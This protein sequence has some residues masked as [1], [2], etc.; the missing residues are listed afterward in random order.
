MT[1]DSDRFDARLDVIPTSPGVY[2]MKDTS[3]S[4][5]YVGKAKNLKNRLGS[6]FAKTPSGNGKVLAM[7]SHI[8]D[9]EYI[10]VNNELE[11]FLLESN[12]I[13]RYQPHYNILLRD[14][15]G[16]PYVCITMNEQYPRIFRSFRVGA[17]RKKGARY[18]GPFLAG[19]LFYALKTLRDVFPMKTCNRS[20][21]R[22]IGKERPCLNY[23]IGKCIAPCRGDV[24]VDDYRKVMENICLFFEGKYTGLQ[25]DME[26]KMQDA[27]MQE[28]FEIAAIFRD[29]LQSL[30]KIMES[31]KVEIA[32]LSDMDIIGMKRNTG[33][34]CI[35]KL[36]CRNGRITGSATFFFLDHKEED[37]EIISAFLSQ[38][39]SDVEE[40]PGEILLSDDILEKESMEEVLSSYA[41]HKVSLRVPK[42]GDGVRLMNMAIH[43]AASALLRRV[44]KV[45]DSKDALEAA[46]EMLQKYTGAP[47]VLGRIEA[48]DISNIGED[49]RCGA[50]VVFRNGKPEK[51]AYRLFKIKKVEGQNDYE[52]MRE[53][54]ERRFSHTEKEGAYPDLILIDGGQGHLAIAREVL[55]KMGL[56]DRIIAA[57][58]VKN[59]KHQTR[60]LALLDGRI[61]E[62]LEESS[63]SSD[64]LILLRLL[65]AIQNEVHRFAINYQ[66]KLSKKRN[67]SFK[68]E[69]IE[70]I[71]PSKRTSLLSHFGTIGKIRLAT[72][73]ELKKAPKIS[74]KDAAAIYQYFH[75]EK[76]KEG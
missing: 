3:G 56:K 36:E 25:K 69:N 40:I 20:F 53:V 75:Q 62:L 58:M 57:G 63:T 30:E 51:A 71:G 2:L 27:A 32:G 1:L 39:Y 74:E 16:Y 67:F 8:A 46:T 26:K 35:R 22:N 76:E 70:G 7:I 49:D 19:D 31:Q 55:L 65:T 44:L 28:K 37:G 17:D 59:K 10:E 29:R 18:Y 73:E 13:K 41:A 42:R 4:I 12:L 9:F 54:L 47:D 15:K 48:Y 38:Y 11:A 68:L 61:I 14:D 50:M 23:H 24:S 34:I 43:N 66:R 64:S 21:P 72:E 60:G 33:E 5:I 52:A 6:Y 45:G